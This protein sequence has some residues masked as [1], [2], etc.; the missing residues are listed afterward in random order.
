M[1]YEHLEVGTKIR[2]TGSNRTSLRVCRSTNSC[3][4]VRYNL[5]HY[6]TRSRPSVCKVYEDERGAAYEAPRW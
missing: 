4:M 3:T 5:E 6:P 2:N 1:R